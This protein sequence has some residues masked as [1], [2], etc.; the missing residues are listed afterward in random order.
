MS[1]SPGLSGALLKGKALRA[2]SPGPGLIS[3]PHRTG[4]AVSFDAAFSF[5]CGGVVGNTLALAAEAERTMTGA[6]RIHVGEN[7]AHSQ[8]FCRDGAI[9]ARPPCTRKGE[10]GSPSLGSNFMAG[11]FYTVIFLIA[12]FILGNLTSGLAK[13]S[14]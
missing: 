10:G 1:I 6:N 12:I 13:G 9:L 5:G 4:H 8:S 2:N 11:L 7:P 3:K 14:L